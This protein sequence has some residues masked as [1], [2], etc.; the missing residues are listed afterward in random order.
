MNGSVLR[1]KPA[2]DLKSESADASLL[3]STHPSD[4]QLGCM[5]A[6]LSVSFGLI[7]GMKW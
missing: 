2:K 4:L 6:M 7:R 3:G 1:L 5:T